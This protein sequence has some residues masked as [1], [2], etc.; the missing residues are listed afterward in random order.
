MND[1]NVEIV[2]YMVTK[3]M[4]DMCSQAKI[5]MKSNTL[6]LNSKFNKKSG[7]VINLEYA[8]NLCDKIFTYR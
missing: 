5:E 8:V 3:L 6:H 7:K 1:Q 2:S 4:N